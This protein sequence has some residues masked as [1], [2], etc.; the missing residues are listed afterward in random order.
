MNL[1]VA[2]VIEGLDTACKENLGFV[3]GSQ[4]DDFI[5]LWRDYDPQATGWISI[6]SLI[7]LLTELPPPLGR[8]KIE[9]DSKSYDA[10]HAAD[11]EQPDRYL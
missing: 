1:S 4:I 2:A 10:K 3:E 9:V 5:E 11:S 8:I 7:F 6:N